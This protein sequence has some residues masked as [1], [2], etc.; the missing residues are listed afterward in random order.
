MGFLNL[1]H[2]SDGK[3]YP[4]AQNLGLLDQ[5]MALKWVHENIESFGGDSGNVTIWGESAGGASVTM[6][7]LIEGSQQ[8]FK[9]VISQSGS[10]SQTNS[11]E[12][13]I[14]CTNELMEKLGCKTVADLQKV[15]ARK[16][17]DTAA[18][19]IAL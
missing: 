3:D 16:L 1:S 13:S 7:P 17:V 4:D 15:D 12:E 9:R 19:V 2:L 14:A 11:L 8:Y 6:L 18:E 10:V 5:K